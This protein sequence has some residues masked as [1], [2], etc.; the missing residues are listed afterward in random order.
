[1]NSKA[2]YAYLSIGA[3]RRTMINKINNG[4]KHNEVKI[5]KDPEVEEF[6]KGFLENWDNLEKF[7]PAAEDLVGLDDKQK[8]EKIKELKQQFCE[9]VCGEDAIAEGYAYASEKKEHIK[10]QIAGAG[11]S[12]ASKARAAVRGI[13]GSD[14]DKPFKKVG[15]NEPCP[16]D[17][18]LKYKKCC[19]N[20]AN[21]N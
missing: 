20:P 11:R 19:G 15:R 16:C 7:P 3:N 5:T 6:Q 13:L 17:S 8:K 4:L 12:V 18:G 21:D 2:V 10:G 9:W 1:M 14:D